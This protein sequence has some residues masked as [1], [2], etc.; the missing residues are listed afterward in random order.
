MSTGND[1]AWRAL[2]AAGLVVMAAYVVA[3]GGRV[4]DRPILRGEDRRPP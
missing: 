3:P 1:R 2:L 4:E